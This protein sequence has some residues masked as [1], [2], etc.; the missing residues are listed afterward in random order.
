MNGFKEFTI[1]ISLDFIPELQ[2]LADSRDMTIEDLIAD[3]AS[4]S[5][6]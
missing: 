2:E 4:S 6:D 1:T 5:I 3:L